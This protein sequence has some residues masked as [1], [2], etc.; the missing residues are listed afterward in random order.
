LTYLLTAPAYQWYNPP[1]QGIRPLHALAHPFGSVRIAVQLLERE[2]R[3][4]QPILPKPGAP[5]PMEPVEAQPP[6]TTIQALAVVTRA[7]LSLALVMPV[8]I[9]TVLG[10]WHSGQFHP[11]AAA[12]AVTGM[13]FSSW[14]L[15]ALGDYS[16]YC[17]G[18]RR[19]GRAVTTSL[20]SGFGLME[21]AI[22]RPQTVRDVGLIGA[23]IG[24]LCTLWLVLLA[25]WPILF[26]SGL[27]FI[28]LA[29]MV[30]LPMHYGH[31]GWGLSE[32]AVF[33]G[34]GMLPMLGS[35]YVQTHMVT[36]LPV[37]VGLPFSALMVLLFL[38]YSAVHFRRDWLI[39]KRTLAVN[40][41]LVRT[42]DV[43]AVLSVAA[44]VGMLM[45]TILTDLPLQAL[46][47]LAAMP[48]GLGAF[49]RLNREDLGPEACVP[50]YRTSVQATVIA[51]L[52]FC[53]ALLLDGML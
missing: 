25:D 3:A 26:F 36:W 27:S 1:R 40:L 12:M 6:R 18:L 33:L 47:A 20:Y 4:T 15:A 19:G 16:D 35:Y 31:R 49:A 10:W 9:G 30:L 28:L 51:A 13:L 43:S 45:V 17:Y 14:S 37:W 42:L 24:A 48:M 8:V 52:L 44:F 38:N 2:Y 32:A 21:Q 23:T 22:L 50:V 11:A 5:V 29:L 7:G 46:I 41:G 53:G 39:R 34:V